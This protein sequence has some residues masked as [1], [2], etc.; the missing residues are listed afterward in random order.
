LGAK[1]IAQAIAIN[2]SLTFLDLSY[3]QIPNEGLKRIAEALPENK[4][5]EIFKL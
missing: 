5:L 2:K 3:N 1:S 4:T